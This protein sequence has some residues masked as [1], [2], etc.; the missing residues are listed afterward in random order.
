[1][2]RTPVQFD[3]PKATG[4]QLT[5]LGQLGLTPMR[6]Q[7]AFESW[8]AW[9]KEARRQAVALSTLDA[10]CDEHEGNY[11]EMGR[12]GTAGVEQTYIV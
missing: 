5:Q 4:E 11:P 6:L 9:E 2:A 10:Q 1:M 12:F 8:I 3:T 7:F